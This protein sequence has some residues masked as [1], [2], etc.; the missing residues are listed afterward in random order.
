MPSK[1]SKRYSAAAVRRAAKRAE[2]AE[3]EEKIASI[4]TRELKAKS[5][6]ARLKLAAERKGF[7]HRWHELRTRRRS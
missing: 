4:K 5:R 7:E 1:N 6:A 3:L 2:R